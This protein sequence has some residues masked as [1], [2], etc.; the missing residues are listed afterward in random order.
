[1]SG[2]TESPWS[3]ETEFRPT[4]VVPP[5]GLSAWETPDV[6]RPTV[7]LDPFLP[8]HLLSRRGEWAE[9]LCVNGWSAWVDGRL[10]VAVPQPPPTGG[11]PL[12][13]GEDPLPL[14]VRTAE[15]LDRYRRA[16]EELASGRSGA[17]EFLRA[18]RGLRAGVVVE[19]G[20]VWLYDEPGG[21]WAYGDGS[22]LGTYAVVTGPGAAAADPAPGADVPAD[23]PAA[24]ADDRP[25]GYEPTRIADV[26]HGGAP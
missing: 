10:L 18:T 7:P 3:G 24:P 20:S 2:P 19:G 15:T 21:R 4:H 22:R 16:A 17:E 12:A 14:L 8:V 23:E 13:R 9:I 5:D 11:Q 25:V 26:P 6:S 1:M